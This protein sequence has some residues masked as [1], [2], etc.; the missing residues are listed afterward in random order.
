MELT[1]LKIGRSVVSYELRTYGYSFSFLPQKVNLFSPVLVWWGVP[2]PPKRLK[3]LRL[4]TDWVGFARC[5][6]FQIGSSPG[7][8]GFLQVPP[9]NGDLLMKTT[10][11]GDVKRFCQDPPRG[12]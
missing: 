6:S 9:N 2:N 3:A 10:R 7:S 5:G 4:S 1:V 8:S 11:T 12:V